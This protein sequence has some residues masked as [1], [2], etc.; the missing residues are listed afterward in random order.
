MNHNIIEQLPAEISMLPK[1]KKLDVSNNAIKYLPADFLFHRLEQFRF[2]GN[3]FYAP[4]SA[5]VKSFLFDAQ[6]EIPLASLTEISAT[7]L[8]EFSFETLP[9]SLKRLYKNHCLCSFCSKDCFEPAVFIEFI[10]IVTR[11][12]LSQIPFLHKLCAV[13]MRAKI[14]E[15]R[16]G[17]FR[18]R[19]RLVD[20]GRIQGPLSDGEYSRVE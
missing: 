15:T 3:D 11:S 10:P 19:Q 1:L 6:Q 20:T 12:N 14:I 4:A 8:T 2:E 16:S 7:A 9:A 17:G 18:L 13:C 5:A